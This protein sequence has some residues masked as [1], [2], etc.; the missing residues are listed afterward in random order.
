MG[1][2]VLFEEAVRR[3]MQADIAAPKISDEELARVVESQVSEA[4]VA[5]REELLSE[6]ASPA[7][8]QQ[9]IASS[10]SESLSK[11]ML[12][13]DGPL[14]K[15]KAELVTKL[16]FRDAKQLVVA[17]IVE[18]VLPLRDEVRAGIRAHDLKL[19]M[20]L[21]PLDQALQKLT[22]SSNLEARLASVE[23]A[24][25][26]QA[27]PLASSEVEARFAAVEEAQRSQ[28]AALESLLEKLELTDAQ[29]SVEELRQVVTVNAG[30]A[31]S[32]ASLRD[33]VQR[34]PSAEELQELT[35][36]LAAQ[37]AQLRTLVGGDCTQA[38]DAARQ[39]A[40][41]LRAVTE[42]VATAQ[43]AAKN[44]QQSA[45]ESLSAASAAAAASE[46]YAKAAAEVRVSDSTGEATVAEA[47]A[48]L[49]ALRGE[50]D[51]KADANKLAE[52]VRSAVEAEVSIKLAPRHPLLSLVAF[53]LQLLGGGV[54]SV[55]LLCGVAALPP[56]PPLP[57]ATLVV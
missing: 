51:R 17:H 24:Q 43:V 31:A 23:E 19:Q 21:G 3:V 2:G 30:L 7:V 32:L 14:E 26:S 48:A 15:V 25:R 50:L 34:Q 47:A 40:E 56:A 12:Q 22:A 27:A 36:R 38:V 37:D 29:P 20:A 42:A 35:S 52:L 45:A 4:V 41:Q 39:A 5:L 53:F 49:A 57:Q 55:A 46:T 54:L 11:E 33:Q 8:V 9:W 10:V 1:G 16:T 6:V 28:A 44:A 13:A 18:A